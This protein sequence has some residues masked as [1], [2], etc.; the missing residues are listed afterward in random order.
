MAVRVPSLDPGNLPSGSADINKPADSNLFEHDS[1]R[2]NY[3][4]GYRA[5]K[6]WPI[7][8]QPYDG[9]NTPASRV[10]PAT[11]Q[12][13]Y[14]NIRT[15]RL[16]SRLYLAFGYFG[17]TEEE[18]DKTYIKVE[19]RKDDGTATGNGSII[20]NGQISFVV[21]EDILWIK[22]PKQRGGLPSGRS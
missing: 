12:T 6:V 9:S 15:S 19:S 17:L 13:R 11:A 4:M 2:V 20:D 14:F 5:L 18:P 21:E 1:D 16:T 3:A 8:L 22:V 7:V 10:Y